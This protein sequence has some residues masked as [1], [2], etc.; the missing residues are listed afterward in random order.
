MPSKPRL[1]PESPV[2][3]TITARQQIFSGGGGVLA[4]RPRDS[5]E[6]SSDPCES[7]LQKPFRSFRSGK[8]LRLDRLPTRVEDCRAS[9]VGSRAVVKWAPASGMQSH[10]VGR[11]RGPATVSSRTVSRGILSLYQLDPAVSY[12]DILIPPRP[13]ESHLPSCFL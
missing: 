8:S 3:P 1:C 11:R 4:T 7:N 12:R 2:S 6:P 5:R 13:S 9:S 10:D